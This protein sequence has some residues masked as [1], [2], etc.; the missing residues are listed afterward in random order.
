MLPLLLALFACQSEIS[1]ESNVPK[2]VFTVTASLPA[3]D[4]TRAV[5]SYGNQNPDK[6]VFEWTDDD[7]ITLFNITKFADFH[8][9]NTAPLLMINNI[10]GIK[11]E[12]EFDPSTAAQ[13]ADG[14]KFFSIMEPGDVIFAILGAAGSA[15]P[16]TEY[17][18]DFGNGI[19][20]YMG[21]NWYSQNIVE[22]PKDTSFYGLYHVHKMMR[23]Y[24]IVE[25]K[26]KGVVP[27]LHFKHL[28]A[29]MRVTL[30]NETGSPL[31]TKSSDLVFS[32]NT[33]DDC[34]FIY[35]FSYFSVVKGDDADG[36][37]LKEN[38]KAPEKRHP[39]NPIPPQKTVTHTYRA[40]HKV[41]MSSSGV[42]LKNGETYDLYAVVAPR[43]GY[44]LTGSEGLDIEL[45][46]NGAETAY[47]VYEDCEKYSIKI[48]DFNM[49]IEAGKRYWFNLT[50]VK[51][52]DGET[53]LMLTSEWL[54]RQ[55][56]KAEN[57]GGETTPEN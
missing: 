9:H 29:I 49:P 16:D 24:D 3:P 53:K 12:F 32:Y 31:F 50:A 8:A 54:K 21:S 17:D 13:K 43:I 28:S 57:Q 4:N 22:N 26:E 45:Y 48:E 34:A 10:N 44:K 39:L 15:D 40:I 25:V 2:R 36:Y 51:E 41:N 38:F 46:N 6:E 11:A 42:P 7:C 55:A 19:S 18:N 56:D 27:D 23:M 35:G 5:I 14:E 47:G 30:R 52:E 37:Y 1:Q 20:C 33:G